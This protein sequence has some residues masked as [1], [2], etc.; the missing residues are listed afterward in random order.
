MEFILEKF[1]KRENVTHQRHNG[2]ILFDYTKACQYARDWDEITL[3]ARGIIFE[4]STGKVIALPFEK[5][6][7][8][9]EPECIR[10]LEKVPKDEP[11]MAQVKKDGSFGICYGY[12]GDW[13][14]NTRGSFH[15]DQAKWAKAWMDANL[16]KAAFILG[17]TYLF[18]I[19]YPENRIVVDYGGKSFLCL[20]GIRDNET[21]I[22]HDYAY[23]EEAAKEIG[24]PV[25]EVFWFK[26]LEELY[27]AQKALTAN[28][29]GFVIT[30][31]KSGLKF[32]LKGDPYCK[33]HR[34]LANLTPLAFWRAIDFEDTLEVPP[35]YVEALPEEFRST[36]DVLKEVTERIHK[37]KFAEIEALAQS[38][39][40]EFKKKGSL[41]DPDSRKRRY[42]FVINEYGPEMASMVLMYLDG[43][44]VKIKNKI[45]KEV[46]PTGNKFE[47]VELDY[48]ILN[49]LNNE[50]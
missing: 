27:E 10:L 45:H 1:L 4:E 26:S 17:K 42:Q 13:H 2:L 18:E 33:I 34:M 21:G 8:H 36:V 43:S 28:E 6:F 20:L 48:R 7:N 31:L 24:C 40:L 41:L 50:E 49:L 9:S 29:E 46:R 3:N 5:F 14:I 32:K 15:S 12:Q 39:P 11:F 23:M 38:V 44:L 16:N 47:G 22:E 25:V 35:H 19:I 37:E 30:Y